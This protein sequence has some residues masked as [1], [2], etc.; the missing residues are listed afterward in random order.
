VTP[1]AAWAG[2][3]AALAAALGGLLVPRVVA[4]LPEPEPEPE[5]ESESPPAPG[6]EPEPG[7]T[8]PAPRGEADGDVTAVSPDR[9]TAPPVPPKIPYAELAARPGLAWRCGLVAAIAAGAMG[10]SRGLEPDLPV[11]VFLAVLGVALGYVDWRTRL[12]PMRLVTPSYGV[13]VVLLLGAYAVERDDNQA[14]RALIAWVAV[15]AI[16]FLLWFIY[17]RGLGYGDVRL[18]GLL[19][20]ALGWLGW[21]AVVVGTYAGF[22][23]GAVG[24]GLLVLLHVVDRRGYPFGPFMLAGA[25]LGVLLAGG[26]LAFWD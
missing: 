17:P 8:H 12:L 21:Q 1:D 9:P 16:Y 5:S 22:L 7:G 24:G 13:V 2:A 3:L 25:L 14:L 15:F 19:G 6:G 10:L 18:S 23:L 4:R 26:D 20:L 11:W